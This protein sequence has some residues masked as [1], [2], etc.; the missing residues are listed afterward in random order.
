MTMIESR[1]AALRLLGAVTAAI[2]VGAAGC[3][4]SG[5]P[6]PGASGSARAGGRGGGKGG[7]GGG[8]GLKYAVEVYPVE[9]RRMQ[10]SVVVPGTLEP[11]E[12]VQVTARV[13]GAVDRVAFADGQKVK[14]GD[15]LVVIDSARYKSAV[16]SAQASLQKAVANQKD[17]EAQL[18]RRKS[19]TDA[20]PGLIPGEE[21]ATYETKTLTTRAD[22]ALAQEALNAATLNLRDS[23]V[24]APMDGVVQTRTVETGQY[25]QAGYLMATLLQSKP[26]LLK[27]DVQPLDAPRLSVGMAAT[28]T[29]RET[30]R[31]FTAKITL[32]AGA[33][34]VDTHMIPV[35]AE[36][37]PTEHE[38][39]LR[40]GSFCEVTLTFGGVREAIVIPRD[41]VRA[42]ERGYVVYTADAGVAHEH[43][44]TLGANSKDGWVEVREG[45]NEGDKLVIRGMEP[46]IEGTAIDQQ[47]VPAPTSS[48]FLPKGDPPPQRSAPPDEPTTSPSASPAS[49]SG[50]GP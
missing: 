46:L 30:D 34:E 38:F 15:V 31:V 26:M 41:A 14:K 28:F 18:A 17:A 24:R 44:V 8:G 49:S 2:G 25:V 27:F 12:H 5:G 50:G 10:Y 42:T 35:T 36:V 11:F 43:V 47:D 21:I 32:I 16:N 9:K 1:R 48:A 33:A 3:K 45:L 37:D 6:R 7:R 22:T 23:E 20:H 4:S 29:M 40:P 39:W 19:A 13:S